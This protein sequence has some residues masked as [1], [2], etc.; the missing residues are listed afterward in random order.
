MFFPHVDGLTGGSHESY[1]RAVVTQAIKPKSEGGHGMRAVV[2][3]F[4]G[5]G[6]P[7]VLT[8]NQLYHGGY[9]DV[10]IA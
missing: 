2:M 10:R 8:S 4:R 9:T 6:Y 7:S 1:I 5:C 3:N